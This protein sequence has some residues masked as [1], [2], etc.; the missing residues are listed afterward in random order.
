MNSFFHLL[1]SKPTRTYQQRCQCQWIPIFIPTV[2]MAI[3]GPSCPHQP[4]PPHP[5]QPPF[6]SSPWHPARSQR[7]CPSFSSAW[8]PP[9]IGKYPLTHVLYIPIISIKYHPIIYLYTIYTIYPLYHPIYHPII[10]DPWGHWKWPMSSSTAEEKSRSAGCAPPLGT[11]FQATPFKCSGVPSTR[12][13]FPGQRMAIYIY[14]YIYT[15]HIYNYTIYHIYIY[16]YHITPHIYI[17]I[18]K[19]I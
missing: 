16:T 6:I 15:T 9:G 8:H 17:Y 1:C 14:I 7:W 10:C 12:I 19:A 4:H 3:Q 5:P 2:F 18:T 11:G 13:C